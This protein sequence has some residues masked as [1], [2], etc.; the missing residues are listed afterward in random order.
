MKLDLLSTVLILSLACLGN[1]ADAQ[2]LAPNQNPAYA[3]SRD[4]YMKT[5][6]SLMQW[7]GTTVQQTYKA[8]DWYEDRQARRDARRQ[9]Q[10]DL[11]LERARRY[12]YINPYDGYYGRPFFNN[13]WYRNPWGF[14][15]F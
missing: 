12:R 8:Y 1:K 15:W 10:R 6:D 11:R 9:F 2:N 7:Q 5:A 3:V 13:Q 4:K 14:N